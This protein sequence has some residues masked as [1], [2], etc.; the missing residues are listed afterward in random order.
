VTRIENALDTLKFHPEPDLPFDRQIQEVVRRLPEVMPVKRAEIEA[1][2]VIS[3]A[4]MGQ[5][6]GVIPRFA[7]IIRENY[8]EEGCKM[9][10][11]LVPGDYD[12]LVAELAKVTKGDFQLEVIGAEKAPAATEDAAPSARAAR[13]GKGGRG[14]RGGKK[15]R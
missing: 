13:G 2:L 14:G 12:A 1:T 15:G 9:E 4:Y 11:G 10:I 8:T 3:H 6:A 5:A 7:K